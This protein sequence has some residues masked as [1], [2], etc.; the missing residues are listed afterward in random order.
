MLNLR[1]VLVAIA[2]DVHELQIQMQRLLRPVRVRGQF[3]VQTVLEDV[4]AEQDP[5]H[6]L[7]SREQ[8]RWK[9]LS[10]PY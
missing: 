4:I 5:E 1:R 10:S 3:L 9:Q 8:W 7:V 2:R 6:Q